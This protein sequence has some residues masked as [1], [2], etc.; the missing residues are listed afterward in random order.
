MT[1]WKARCPPAVMRPIADGPLPGRL[2]QKAD[3]IALVAEVWG[4]P[5]TDVTFTANV[6]T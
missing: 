3:I 5:I 6:L 2:T 1:D 4:W